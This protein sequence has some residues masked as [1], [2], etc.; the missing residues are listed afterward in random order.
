MAPGET[1]WGAK[2]TD[3]QLSR[4]QKHSLKTGLHSLRV[5]KGGQFGPWGGDR[6]V[7]S[8]CIQKGGRGVGGLVPGGGGLAICGGVGGWRKRW[9]DDD[10][11]EVG[12][13]GPIE[14]AQPSLSLLLSTLTGRPYPRSPACDWNRLPNCAGETPTTAPNP[15]HTTGQTHGAEVESRA[16]PRRLT[17]NASVTQPGLACLGAG[18]GGGYQRLAQVGQGFTTPLTPQT[19]PVSLEAEGNHPTEPGRRRTGRLDRSWGCRGRRTRRVTECTGAPS[20]AH[21]R[22]GGWGGM[23]KRRG[24]MI[25]DKRS[26]IMEKKRSGEL[27][28]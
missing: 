1:D 9:C 25:K 24:A 6:D 28:Q 17:L 26:L 14:T 18:G 27:R 12:A 13:R 3:D 22:H 16:H 7:P 10:G 20:G 4:Q 8:H 19:R 23:G 15:P 21:P 2:G 5:V 11:V